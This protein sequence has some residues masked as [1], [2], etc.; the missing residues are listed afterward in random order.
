MT[1]P[2]VIVDPVDSGSA[3]APAFAARGVPCVAVRSMTPETWAAVNEMGFAAQ[4]QAEHFLAVHEL[5]PDLV[6][7]LRQHEP[8]VVIAGAESGVELADQLAAALTPEWAN[9]PAL[10]KARRHKG[11]MQAALA[12]AGLPTIRTLNTGSAAEVEAWLA[13]QGLGGS[14]LVLKPAA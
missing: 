3:L 7:R 9:L 12:Q 13:E 2:I 4:I 5:G 6:Q 14:G 1:R 10:A 8:L 11:Q